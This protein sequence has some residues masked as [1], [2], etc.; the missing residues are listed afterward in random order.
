MNP[1][2]DMPSSNIA[3]WE[4]NENL[5]LLSI[6][7]KSNQTYIYKQVPPEI[8]LGAMFCDSIGKYF[9]ANVKNVFEFK[10]VTL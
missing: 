4:Y 6:T 5:N 3:K 7:F 10:K 9:N 1:V 2:I 8:H